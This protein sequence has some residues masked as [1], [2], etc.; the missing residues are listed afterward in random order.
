MDVGNR[1]QTHDSTDNDVTS[2]ITASVPA[3]EV[4]SEAAFSSVDG[5]ETAP[6]IMPV[7]LPEI[8]VVQASPIM[9]KK[10]EETDDVETRD[11]ENSDSEISDSENTETEGNLVWEHF[12]C[13]T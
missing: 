8:K 1:K 3:T 11:T 7:Q 6:K 5:N 4:L 12:H 13:G 10:N 9:T 2:K